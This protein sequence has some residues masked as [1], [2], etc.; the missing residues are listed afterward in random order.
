ME[1]K[2]KRIARKKALEKR[3]R[4]IEKALLENRRAHA[5]NKAARD[6][7][8]AERRAFL[9]VMKDDMKRLVERVDSIE[10]R[11]SCVEDLLQ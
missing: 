7:L 1:S 3:F 11:I 9:E 2:R 4:A 5:E 10:F 6:A 8:M